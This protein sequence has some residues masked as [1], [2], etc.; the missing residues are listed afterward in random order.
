MWVLFQAIGTGLGIL[1]SPHVGVHRLFLFAFHISAFFHSLFIYHCISSVFLLY[2]RRICSRS[3]DSSLTH[4]LGE[5]P[6]LSD[7]FLLE[8]GSPQGI[9]ISPVSFIIMLG[10]VEDNYYK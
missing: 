4:F 9:D 5:F 10:R 2:D 7:L 8:K 6:Y 3:V 1:G